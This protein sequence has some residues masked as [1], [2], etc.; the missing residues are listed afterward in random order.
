MSKNFN[1]DQ[2]EIQN[3]FGDIKVKL[4]P[5]PAINFIN[6]KFENQSIFL[7]E[8]SIIDIYGRTILKNFNTNNVIFITDLSPGSYYIKMVIENNIIIKKFIK[9]K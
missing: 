4:F 3:L 6:I 1:T 2:T 8:V 9:S 7:K 5:N